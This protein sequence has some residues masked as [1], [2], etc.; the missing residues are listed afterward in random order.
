[1]TGSEDRTIRIWPADGIPCLKIINN[2]GPVT[3]LCIDSLNGCI[4][5]GSQDH[6]IRVF[7]PSKNDND[8]VQKNVGHSD[9][10]KAIV[11]VPM[12]NQVS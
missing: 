9:E 3:S 1:M 12:R 6:I 4:V 11:H 10:V 8:V 2:D 7:D 5:T